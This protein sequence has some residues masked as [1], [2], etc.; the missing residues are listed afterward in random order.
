M[1]N[2]LHRL[3][4]IIAIAGCTL[5]AN[6]QCADNIVPNGGLENGMENW[7]N[8]HDNNPD[9]YSFSLSADAYTGDS[10]MAINILT[11]ADSL[12]SFQGAEYNNRP[13]VMPV[14]AG[15]T[16]EISF[17]VKST[18]ADA[19]MSLW[20]KDEFDNWFTLHNE[21]FTVGTEWQVM[22]TQ[23]TP[24]TDRADIHLELKAYSENINEP[25]TILFDEIHL[26]DATSNSATCASNLISNPGF[27]TFPNALADWWNWHGGTEEAYAFYASADAAEGDSSAVMDILW[28]SNDI[29]TGP[30][31]YN[32]RGMIIPVAG[33]E[34]YEVSFAAKSTIDQSNIQVWVKDEFDSWFTIYNTDFTITTEWTNYSFL[35]Q[36]DA[37]RD[38][39]HLELK[40]FNEGFQPYKVFFDEV[41]ICPSDPSTITCADN[42]I[43]NP[44][45]EDGLTDWWNWHGGDETDYAFEQSSEAAVGS[46]SLLIKVL[47]P[48][49]EITGTGEFNSR[50]QVSPVVAGQNYSVSVWAKSSLSGAGIQMWV[51]DEFDGWTTIGNDDAVLTTE[52]AEYSFIFANETDRDDIHL[53][54]KVYT[55]GAAAAYDVWLDEMSICE[56]DDDPGSGDPMPEIYTYGALDTLIGCSTSMAFEFTDTDIDGD[57]TGWEVWD[58]S[59]E[60]TLS[61][62]QFDPVLPYSGANSIRVDVNE[63]NNVAELHHRF[64]DRFDLAEG[65]TYTLTLWARGNIP[66]DDTLRVYA[67]TVRD[68]D[69]KEPGHGN[70][71]VVSNEWRNY[72]FEFTPAEDFNNAFLDIK[73]WRWNES[74]FT[75]AYTVWYDDIQL[76]SSDD[77]TVMVETG[78]GFNELENLGVDFNLSPNPVVSGQMAQLEINA[79]EQLLNTTI[80]VVDVLGKTHSEF[81]ADIQPGTEQ[82]DISTAGLPAGLF[83]IGVHYKNYNKTIKLQ[84]L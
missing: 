44:G 11:D 74:G 75:E 30:A 71:M 82:L 56:T 49:A 47:K 17:A 59:D 25:Y 33:G 72:S 45:G 24:V 64:A 68:T 50:P 61:A 29:T 62:W 41:A 23:F 73:A 51:K 22:T 36:S 52:W 58:G 2:I 60:E 39:I 40:V 65:T 63:G 69:W 14:N 35:F 26:C 3:L 5:A 78:V 70:F 38:D 54:L 57:G 48:T 37:D 13:A 83:F 7:G 31:E 66:A 77:R 27:E 15:V 28:A 21:F 4:L 80:R 32:N 12:T 9:A 55:D 42:L 16:Y 43:S 76:C 6:A 34:F 10:S 67:R 8:W 1:K 20:V 18:V 53:E 84:I 46:S 79:E 81:T 19:M